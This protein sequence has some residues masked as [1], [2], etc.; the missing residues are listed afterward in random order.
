MSHPQ[1][2]ACLAL[3]LAI[4][5]CDR[6]VDT[7]HARSSLPPT[8]LVLGQSAVGE[9]GLGKMPDCEAGVW[10]TLVRRWV[11]ATARR[12]AR[13]QRAFS[14]AFQ[15]VA[16]CKIFKGAHVGRAKWVRTLPDTTGKP[17]GWPRKLRWDVH[18]PLWHATYLRAGLFLRGLVPDPCDGEPVHTGGKMDR[19]RMNPKIWCEVSCGE[20]KRGNRE[21]FFWERCR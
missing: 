6:C 7:A 10:S 9:C 5:C 1:F 13:G 15:F 16:Y 14:M 18:E 11:E 21:Q 19:H 4:V 8:Q 12:L 2:L 20:T 17:S 3:S